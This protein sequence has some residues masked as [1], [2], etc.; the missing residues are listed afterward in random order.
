MGNYAD[1]P[2]G[3][4]HSE[5]SATSF[6]YG[7]LAAIGIQSPLHEGKGSKQVFKRALAAHR[8]APTSTSAYQSTYQIAKLQSVNGKAVKQ[9]TID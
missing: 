2:N 1:R 3:L 6:Q 7:D 5:N 4:A 8:L 9:E